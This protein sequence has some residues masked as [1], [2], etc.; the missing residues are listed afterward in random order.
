L[1]DNLPNTVLEALACGTPVV[2]FEVGGIPDM[3]RPGVT[4]MLAPAQ[5]LRALGETIQ[6]ILNNDTLRKK[7]S[8]NCRRVAVEE[9]SLERQAK[10]YLGLY[11]N[12]LK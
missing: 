1:Q 5:D 8:Q 4:G 10:Q 9:Y 11:R 3:V 6:S 7:I 2:G 12:I